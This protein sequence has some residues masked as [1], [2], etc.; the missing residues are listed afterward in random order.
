MLHAERVSLKRLR[1]KVGGEALKGLTGEILL[2]GFV[3]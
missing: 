2:I 3:D 1:W